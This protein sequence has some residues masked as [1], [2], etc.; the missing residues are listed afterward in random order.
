MSKKPLKGIKLKDN[1]I[2]IKKF[3]KVETTKAGI[4]LPDEDQEAP[5]GGTI[6]SVGPKA[7]GV[8]VGEKVRF[9]EHGMTVEIDGQEYYLLRD[10]DVWGEIE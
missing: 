3:D 8:E 10:G 6:V 2:L 7:D 4:I 1:R 9:M 5:E